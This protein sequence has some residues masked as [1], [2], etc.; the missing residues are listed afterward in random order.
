MRLV[1]S[2]LVVLS[3]LPVP[4]QQQPTFRAGTSLVPVNV[5]VIDDH[6]SPVTNL[7]Q[8]D[9]SVFEDGA[10]QPIRLFDA[11]A[12]T[13]AASGAVRQSDAAAAMRV[14]PQERRVFLIVLG[15]GRLNQVSNGIDAAVAFVG[16][17]LLPQDL[18]AVLAWNRATAFTTDRAFILEVLHRFC[19]HARGRRPEDPRVVQ[20]TPRIVRASH[21]TGL[22]PG[23]D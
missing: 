6:G 21:D 2:S 3:L 17:R 4:Q 14:L 15:R 1:L 23:R 18:V 5:R 7:R 16:Q 20:R 9:F 12:L 10:L 11:H 8:E 19:T 13:P 22:H